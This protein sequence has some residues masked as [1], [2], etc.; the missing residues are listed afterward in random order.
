MKRHWNEDIL[1]IPPEIDADGGKRVDDESMHHQ[2]YCKRQETK[3]KDVQ[4]EERQRKGGK[5]GVPPRLHDLL[6]L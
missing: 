5:T 1:H 3:R 6:M 4:Y 2:T